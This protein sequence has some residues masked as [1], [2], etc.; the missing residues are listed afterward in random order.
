MALTAL[1]FEIESHIFDGMWLGDLHSLSLACHRL[2]A[3]V[4]PRLWADLNFV[5]S[6]NE[7]TLDDYVRYGPI[8]KTPE[9]IL[10]KRDLVTCISAHDRAFRFWRAAAI[11]RDETWAL[12]KSLKADTCVLDGSLIFYELPREPG[13]IQN[14]EF[15]LHEGQFARR[16]ARILDAG[17]LLSLRR[18]EIEL[19]GSDMGCGVFNF[20]ALQNF[21]R[22]LGRHAG[23]YANSFEVVIVAHSLSFLESFAAGS[24]L[25]MRTVRI[26]KVNILE[27]SEHIDRLRR[28][29]SDAPKLES[30]SIGAATG[31]VRDPTYNTSFSEDTDNEDGRYISDSL[32]DA[33]AAL[34]SLQIFA[35]NIECGLRQLHSDCFP[36]H[37][38]C[39]WAPATLKRLFIDAN[40]LR[41]RH[42]G[43]FWR[44]FASLRLPGLDLLTIISGRREVHTRV[45]EVF[46]HD[47]K[48]LQLE[49]DRETPVGLAEAIFRANPGLVHINT[50]IYSEE[51]IAVLVDNNRRKPTLRTFRAP[52]SHGTRL[53]GF[54][55]A[56]IERLAEAAA[57]TLRILQIPL[58]PVALLTEAFV[59][60]VIISAEMLEVFLVYLGGTQ[61][62]NYSSGDPSKPTPGDP[63]LSRYIQRRRT[64]KGTDGVLDWKGYMIVSA[65]I[66]AFSIDVDAFRRDCGAST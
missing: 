43:I 41:S 17:K 66:G 62:A 34:P 9:P 38:R 35:G 23:Y 44:N 63:S 3:A 48:I 42:Y 15:P 45:D 28:L 18:A 57:T 13:Y 4:N 33:I 1:P 46:F 5:V 50:S 12:V 27:W 22:S 51:A 59:R 37:L 58:E 49:V 30:L 40:G 8:F 24:P 39:N 19:S 64:N 16:I 32:Q 10:S 36:H 61:G 7:W 21:C 60:S 65:A 6:H 20:P 26:L 56:G 2:H 25:A 52:S 11:V 29:L 53:S 55:F 14:Y 54:D 47:L 31:V